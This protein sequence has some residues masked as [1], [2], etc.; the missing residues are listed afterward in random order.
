MAAL[1]DTTL[2]EAV[3]AL[4]VGRAVQAF[5][6]RLEAAYALGSLAHGGFSSLVSDVDLGL[7]LSDPLTPPD[8]T[9]IDTIGAQVRAT[10]APLTDRLSVFWGS[11]QSL[12]AGGAP[13]RFPP[14]DRLDLLQYGRLLHGQ[15][16]RS[17]LPSPKHRELVLEAARY[18]LLLVERYNLPACVEDPAGLLAKGARIYT[19]TVLFP[20]RFLYT[21]RTGEIGRNHDAVAHLVQH[22]PGDAADLAA[23]ALHWREWPAAPEDLPAQALL[24]A[25]LIPLYRSCLEEHLALAH[26]WGED[27][28]AEELA[29]ARDRLENP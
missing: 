3:L 7:I 14:L 6:A 10:G 29:A 20:A 9:V 25:G 15:D 18:C 2:G 24:R 27:R 19:K 23:A 4:A 17:G 5:G 12:S 28:L 8:T 1:E 26:P 11:R 21:A 22:H 16:Q 13:G